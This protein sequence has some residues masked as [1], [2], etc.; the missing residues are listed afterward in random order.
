LKR[1]YFDSLVFEPKALCDLI[2]LAD[3]HHIRIGT[4]A[5]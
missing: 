5:R 1:I 2:D 4:D 3:C